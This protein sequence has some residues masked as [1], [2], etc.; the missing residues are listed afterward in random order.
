MTKELFEL[1]SVT[2]INDYNNYNQ[3]P[4]DL[5]EVVKSLKFQYSEEDIDALAAWTLEEIKDVNLLQWTVEV[6]GILEEHAHIEIN[7]LECLLQAYITLYGARINRLVCNIQF[8]S[9]I[10][11][12]DLKGD[13]MHVM[14]YICNYLRDNLPEINTDKT[15]ENLTHLI[16]SKVQ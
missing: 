3:L 5:S 8:D 10:K 1:L 11:K 9:E 7:S 6:R 12:V 14:D 16:Y 15:I 13:I 4:N 2:D